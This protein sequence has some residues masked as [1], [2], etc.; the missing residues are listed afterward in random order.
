MCPQTPTLPPSVKGMWRSLMRGAERS[1]SKHVHKC[2]GCF[3]R[4]KRAVHRPDGP[5]DAPRDALYHSG[6]CSRPGLREAERREPA[7][8]VLHFVHPRICGDSA[9]RMS[10]WGDSYK[11]GDSV[12]A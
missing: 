7:E 5:Q 9:G 1:V 6:D 2:P 8:V 11:V 4:V 10:C 12:K 3:R